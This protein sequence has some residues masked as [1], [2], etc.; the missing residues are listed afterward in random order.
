MKEKRNLFKSKTLPCL[1]LAFQVLSAVFYY[2]GRAMWVFTDITLNIKG[3]TFMLLFLMLAN[4]LLLCT[5][6]ALRIYEKEQLYSKKI[7]SV[8]LG[9]SAVIT[10]ASFIYAAIASVTMITDEARQGFLLYVRESLV[11]AFF[12]TVLPFMAIFFHKLPCKAKKAV[13]AAAVI[14]TL[15]LAASQLV[16]LTP[17]KITS[18]PMVIDNGKG[19]S[20]VFSTNDKGTGYVE[21][22]FEGK[23][24]KVYDSDGGKL[25]TDS[26][27]HSMEVPYEHLRNN[28]YKVGS[29]RVIEAYSYGS[30][31]GKEIVSD[32]YT[33][34]YVDSENQ[35]WLVVSDWHTM[36][37]TAYEA[38]DCLGEYDSVILLG[39]ATPGVDFEQQVVTNIVEFG[40]E[41][42][43]GTKP[44][45]YVRG[46]HET[47]GNYAGKLGEAL[48]L[49]K[50]YYTADVGPYSFIL[51]DSGEDKD[52]SHPEYGGTT[53]YNTYRADM[54]EWLSGT[55]PANDKV[56]SLCHSWRIS[57]VE[58]ELSDK[59]WQ[60]L[61]RI[62]TRLMISGH[63]HQC[64]LLGDGS[65]R[66]KEIF[67]R[68]PHIAGY[69]DG[70][71]QGEDFIAT[72]MTL[73]EKGINL[74]S[75][76]NHGQTVLES[77]FEW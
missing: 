49:E 51:L 69:L 56:I 63:E 33:L 65:D 39:D 66:E 62:G 72:K 68:Y 55:E 13:S 23:D 25:N 1:L 4:T 35:K 19:Y 2:A 26:T 70:G 24:Y 60:E 76:D 28:S 52:D 8:L 59:G 40:S 41:V 58:Q 16:P 12:F 45:L 48:G 34:S 42:S 22:T 46:N 17:Y 74:I 14:I 50:F 71:K 38:I 21:Y 64:R 10:L 9:I 77:S 5:L 7:Y 30:R 61:D 31:L 6:S 11:Y 67:S 53:D 18:Q 29:V 3:F 44:V 20:V 27:I 43:Q 57:D 75:I 54:I 47:R 15:L 36:L 32:E 73:S 37:G